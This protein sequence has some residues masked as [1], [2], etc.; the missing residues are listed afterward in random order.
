[1]IIKVNPTGSGLYT[2]SVADDHLRIEFAAGTGTS[3]LDV[4]QQAIAAI[5]GAVVKSLNI[6]AVG[7]AT[8]STGLWF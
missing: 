1:M 3:F 8:Q 6:D 5:R 2:W 4:G 7:T